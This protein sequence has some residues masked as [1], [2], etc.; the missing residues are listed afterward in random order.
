METISIIDS[1]MIVLGFDP[2]LAQQRLQ[3]VQSAAVAETLLDSLSDMVMAQ[4]EIGANAVIA[5]NT[6]IAATLLVE[7]NKKTVNDIFLSTAAKEVLIFTQV[8][9][10]TLQGIAFQC[11][12]DGGSAVYEAR[13]LLALVEDNVYDDD[14]SCSNAQ[15]RKGKE[16]TILEKTDGFLL[17]P[18][19][20]THQVTLVLPGHDITTTVNLVNAQGMLVLER[21][22]PAKTRF[23][24][25]PTSGLAPGL[26]LL[27]VFEDNRKVFTEKLI[28]AY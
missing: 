20:T 3:E 23:E 10:N 11:P 15:A 16:E 13:S 24:T 21:K 14:L 28:I 1:Q 26:Y 22:L 18:N 4:R 9:R 7:T 6:G 25:I 19:P 27:N 17:F 5:H 2:V 12:L 8:Q